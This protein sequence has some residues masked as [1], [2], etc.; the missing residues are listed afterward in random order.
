MNDLSIMYVRYVWTTHNGSMAVS[1][2]VMNQNLFLL[3]FPP[4]VTPDNQARTVGIDKHC[5]AVTM[6][7]EFQPDPGG[8]I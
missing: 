6:I 4:R 2:S 5:R 8:A 1:V 3:E 7:P